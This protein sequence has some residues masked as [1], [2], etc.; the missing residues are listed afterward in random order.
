MTVVEIILLALIIVGG[1][2]ALIFFLRGLLVRTSQASQPY[3]V[4]RQESRHEEGQLRSRPRPIERI[5]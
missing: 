5:C 2:A 4:A 1:A 3:G